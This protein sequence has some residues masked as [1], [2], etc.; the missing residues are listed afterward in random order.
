MGNLATDIGW[1]K[2][3]KVK[4]GI[5]RATG[6]RRSVGT[7]TA[8][9]VKEESHSD[10]TRYTLRSNTCDMVGQ[11]YKFT[12]ADQRTTTRFSTALLSK[13]GIPVKLRRKRL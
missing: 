7:A 2:W 9:S 3:K 1:T 10:S 11:N 12:R 4:Q 6:G 8:E 13:F 5:Q